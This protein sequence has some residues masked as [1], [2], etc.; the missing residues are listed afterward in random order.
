MKVKYL[1]MFLL[2]GNIT[3]LALE[4]IF[5]NT[6]NISFK[7]RDQVFEYGNHLNSDRFSY[8]HFLM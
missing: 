4:I 3:L 1:M 5:L 8:V 2:L 7:S 6:I